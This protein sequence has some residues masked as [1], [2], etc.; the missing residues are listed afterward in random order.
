[1]GTSIRKNKKVEK[2]TEFVERFKKIQKEA[3]TVLRKTQ[4]KIKQQA[5]KRR[6][7]IEE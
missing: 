2:A 4:E 7:E 5:D 1:M 3:Q 6:S